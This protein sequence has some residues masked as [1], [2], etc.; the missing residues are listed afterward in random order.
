[1]IFLQ[2]SVAT[3]GDAAG[4]TI[5]QESKVQGFESRSCLLPLKIVN[6]CL[7]YCLWVFEFVIVV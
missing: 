6:E 1:V 7:N 5:D 2:L 4:R 3:G